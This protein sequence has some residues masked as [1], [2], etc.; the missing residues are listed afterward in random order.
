MAVVIAERKGQ[1]GNRC[2]EPANGFTMSNRERK[3]GLTLKKWDRTEKCI[4]NCSTT[5]ISRLLIMVF[6]E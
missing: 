1:T 5:S 4:F 6:F 3:E 2:W